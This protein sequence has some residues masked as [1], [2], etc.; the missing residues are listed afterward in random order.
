MFQVLC[1]TP[2]FKHSLCLAQMIMSLFE[3]PFLAAHW[4][5]LL[6]LLG[7]EPLEDAVHMETVGALSPNQWAVITRH[8]TVRAAA[9]ERHSANTAVLVISDP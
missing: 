5:L 8:L 3:L 6:H 2:A 1:G 7:V 4:A 9:V